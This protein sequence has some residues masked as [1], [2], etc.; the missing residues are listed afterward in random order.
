[1]KDFKL[2]ELK[3]RLDLVSQEEGL[4]LI[5]MWVKQNV[6]TQ[7]QFIFLTKHLHNSK[8]NCTFVLTKTEKMNTTE[9]N[10]LLAEF[11]GMELTTDGISQLYYTEDRSLR[12]I[13]KFHT[14]WNWLMQVV[15]KI[16]STDLYYDEYIDYNASMFTNG[17][18]ELSASI[19]HVYDQ[20][21]EFVKWYNE[22]KK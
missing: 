21:V 5:Y 6:I 16:F 8:L 13:P 18:I 4:K 1:M 2:E 22:Q 14:D 15:D 17:Q 12:Q 9:S 10:K 20:C 19:K 7:K 11:L 3:C